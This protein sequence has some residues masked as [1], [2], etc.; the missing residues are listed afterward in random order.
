MDLR[1]QPLTASG[2]GAAITGVDLRVTPA[3]ALDGAALRSLLHE[4]GFLLFRRG[5]GGA[6]PS[7]SLSADSPPLLTPQQQW[8]VYQ[9]FDH[10]DFAGDYRS[11]DYL[12]QGGSWNILEE[13]PHTEVLGTVEGARS[14]PLAAGFALHTD[15]IMYTSTPPS[16]VSMYAVETPANGAGDTRFMSG[17]LAYE[18]LSPSTRER[19]DGLYQVLYTNAN[20][21]HPQRVTATNGTRIEGDVQESTNNEGGPMDWESCEMM[22][23]TLV[24]SHPVT[25]R[26]SIWTNGGRVHRLLERD[27]ATGRLT[28]LGVAETRQL[29]EALLAPGLAAGASVTHSHQWAV[30]DLV[31]FDNCQILHQATDP[32]EYEGHRRHLQRI[33][34]RGS[35]SQADCLAHSQWLR[36]D[37]ARP[38]PPSRPVVYPI[39]VRFDVEHATGDILPRTFGAAVVGLSPGALK[40]NEVRQMLRSVW[41]EHGGLLVR[42][43]PCATPP[44]L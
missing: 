3:S 42:T 18:A 31:V 2:F 30:G 1:A 43:V 34:M 14:N 25:G 4:H 36:S 39:S 6:A 44:I 41:Q 32:L 11:A 12:S 29:M 33:E 20:A 5:G 38:Q 37:P 8:A 16:T 22:T 35:W 27:R 7:G 13:E 26:R 21:K 40:S 10:V 23:T 28:A 15:G 9:H 24:R 19:A 17:A